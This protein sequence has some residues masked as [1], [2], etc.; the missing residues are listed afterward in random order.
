MTDPVTTNIVD[1]TFELPATITDPMYA[2]VEPLTALNLTTGVGGT[3]IFDS[4][5]TSMGA[6]LQSQFE[7]GRITGSE[8]TKAYIAM[9]QSAMQFAVQFA[10]GKDQAFWQAQQAQVDAITARINMET[11]RYAFL[12]AQYNYDNVLPLQSAGLTL[13]NTGK[14]TANSISAYNLATIL[15]LQAAG[16]TIDNA[17]RTTEGSIQAYNLN[18]MLPLQSGLLTLQS[19]GEGIKNST[20]SYNLSTMLPAQ[21]GLISAQTSQ[22][23][24]QATLLGAQL[25]QLNYQTTNLLPAQ[26][27]L[28]KEQMEVQHAQTSATRSDGST[29]VTGV[30][31]SQVALYGQQ[32][33]SYKRDAEQKFIKIMT[34]SWI[35]QKTM[36]D[37]TVAP[38][39]MTNLAI[40]NVLSTAM[41]NLAL[42]TPLPPSSTTG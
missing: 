24:A 38:Q 39:N 33:I 40:D 23:T 17:N 42:A 32:V 21:V 11:A 6:Q 7:N 8:Y 18:T 27:N 22:A 31:G 2:K 35:T 29:P 13:D 34:D 20:A 19:T 14:T 36:D 5:M 16:A 28:V 3:G 1:P 9:F 30:L 15:P 10:L 26:L 4:L 25:N 41:T 12:S 37:G